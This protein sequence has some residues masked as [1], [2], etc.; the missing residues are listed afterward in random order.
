MSTTIDV[1]VNNIFFASSAVDPASG[2]PVYVFDS[3]YLPSFD[4]IDDQQVYDLLVDK[5]MDRV[6]EMCIRDRYEAKHKLTNLTTD[7]V[8]QNIKRIARD[9]NAP[10]TGEQAHKKQRVWDGFSS[11][12]KQMKRA[13]AEGAGKEK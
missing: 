3:T 8:Y 13:T 5:L 10:T 6:V 2:H 11:S 4:A 9:Q 1:N 7:E 12:V